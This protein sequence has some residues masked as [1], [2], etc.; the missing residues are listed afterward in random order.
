MFLDPNVDDVEKFVIH[1]GPIVFNIPGEARSEVTI[2]V[3]ELTA[4][5]RE[6]SL[7]QGK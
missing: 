1:I 4:S 2:R 5:T 3:L 7:L 6:R